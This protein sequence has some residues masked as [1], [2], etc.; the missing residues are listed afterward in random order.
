MELEFLDSPMRDSW[1][2]LQFRRVLQIAGTERRVPASNPVVNRYRAEGIGLP[3]TIYNEF[4]F[5]TPRTLEL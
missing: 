4:V 1:D 3:L 2:S 5:Q